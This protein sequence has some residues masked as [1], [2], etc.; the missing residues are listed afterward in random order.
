MTTLGEIGSEAVCMAVDVATK[1]PGGA[2]VEDD[3]DI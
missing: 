1:G 2:Q 3:E